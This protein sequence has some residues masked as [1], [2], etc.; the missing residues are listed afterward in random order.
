MILKVSSN[1]HFRCDIIV[2]KTC[3]SPFGQRDNYFA[4]DFNHGTDEDTGKR[5]SLNKHAPKEV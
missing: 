1:Q 2:N 3:S 5:E 4:L